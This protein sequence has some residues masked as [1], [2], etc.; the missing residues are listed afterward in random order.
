MV[1]KLSGGAREQA[2][3]G[4]AGWR[5]ATGRDAIEK[6]FVFGDFN[7]AFGFMAR[8]ALR[9][10]KM[11]HHPEWFNVYNRVEVTLATHDAGGVTDLDI[12]L[13]RFLDKLASA[14]SP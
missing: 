1:E 12:T 14:D 6:T 3:A 7:E 10:E 13:A 8:V 11:N 2:L 9:A 4:L 5:E